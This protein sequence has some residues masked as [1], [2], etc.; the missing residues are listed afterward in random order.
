MRSDNPLLSRDSVSLRDLAAENWVFPDKFT[1]LF[2]YC[3]EMFRSA[4]FW[5]RVAFTE[6]MLMTG[7][8]PRVIENGCVALVPTIV[9]NN[10]GSPHIKTMRLEQDYPV[11]MMLFYKPGKNRNLSSIVRYLSSIDTTQ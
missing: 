4:G 5:P 11:N 7:V 1:T 9:A 10:I 8:V 3:S 6:H 2:D